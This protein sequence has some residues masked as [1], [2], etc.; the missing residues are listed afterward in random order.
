MLK[1][2]LV[3]AAAAALTWW[4]SRPREGGGAAQRKKRIKM[5]KCPRCGVYRERGQPCS[6]E[7]G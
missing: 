1:W 7:K 5:E 6:C 2:L 3:L 4:A